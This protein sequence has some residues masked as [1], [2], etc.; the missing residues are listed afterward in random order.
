MEARLCQQQCF[1]FSFCL[2]LLHWSHCLF[3][4]LFNIFFSDLSGF[5][6]K[7]KDTNYREVVGK[8][9]FWHIT[10]LILQ[11]SCPFWSVFICAQ[12]TLLQ[13]HCHL[14]PCAQLLVK[15]SDVP[16]LSAG[17]TCSFGNLTEVEGQVNGNQILCI[18]P[19]AKDVPLIPTDQGRYRKHTRSMRRM[20]MNGLVPK[21]TYFSSKQSLWRMLMCPLPLVTNLCSKCKLFICK[22]TL[23]NIFSD[24]HSQFIQGLLSRTSIHW[25]GTVVLL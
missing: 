22:H 2:E 23:W 21:N 7:I 20:L 5:L 14:S 11:H 17:I 4:F 16:D 8:P 10:V 15:V 13:K 3:F 18:S 19:A 24:Q 1:L 9:Y 6:S 25:L 12:Q